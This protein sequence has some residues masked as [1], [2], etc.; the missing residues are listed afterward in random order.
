MPI[1]ANCQDSFI[2]LLNVARKTL[3]LICLWN[4]LMPSKSRCGRYLI[5]AMR[6]I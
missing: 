6:W 5:S 4:L 3:P 2:V 1:T